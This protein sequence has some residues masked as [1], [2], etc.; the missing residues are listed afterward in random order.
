MDV[1]ISRRCR[2]L[3]IIVPTYLGH[4]DYVQILLESLLTRI[5]D[6][7]R[8]SLRLVVGDDGENLVF[9]QRLNLSIIA[10]SSSLDVAVAPLS[11]VLAHYN[12]SYPH[13]Q[14]SALMSDDDDRGIR[15]ANASTNKFLF[16]FTKKLYGAR[17]FSGYEQALILD[18]ESS[19]LQPNTSL[20]SLF[21][22]ERGRPLLFASHDT[23]L[24]V[25]K[26]RQLT[27]SCLGMLGMSLP[28]G[29]HY[30]PNYH[31]AWGQCTAISNLRPG[32]PNSCAGE[33]R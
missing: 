16:Q 29:E 28:P 10:S 23:L 17:F 4:L 15:G 12:L 32:I 21:H 8:V 20:S 22:A 6:L 26:L 31:Y 25:R 9:E 14:S 1:S 33:M 3:L 18:S 24:E 30:G 11:Q 2:R 13:F 5:V 7:D 19:I 27:S